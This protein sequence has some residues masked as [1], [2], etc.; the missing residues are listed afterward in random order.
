MKCFFC[1]SRAYSDDIPTLSLLYQVILNKKPHTLAIFTFIYCFGIEKLV[2]CNYFLP[3]I[4]TTYFSS[5]KQ[6]F[7]SCYLL[8]V[9]TD[10]GRKILFINIETKDIF[11]GEK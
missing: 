1:I 4:I 5:V 11:S 3:T 6:F 10:L 9:Q 8:S 2:Y 7:S